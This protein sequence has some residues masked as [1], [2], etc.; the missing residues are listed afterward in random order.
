LN[1]DDT[2]F[3]EDEL[4]KTGIV[5]EKFIK[6][7]KIVLPKDEDEMFRLTQKGIA[8]SDKKLIG[9]RDA[10]ADTHSNQP[11]DSKL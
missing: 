10:S 6:T 9:A 1:D 7:Q 2:T 4:A 8:V 5:K 3:E 11:Q